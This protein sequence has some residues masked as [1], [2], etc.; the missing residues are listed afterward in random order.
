MTSKTV[1]TYRM[2]VSNLFPVGQRVNSHINF[3]YQINTVHSLAHFGD[4]KPCVT[5]PAGLQRVAEAFEWFKTS[6]VRSSFALNVDRWVRLDTKIHIYRINL[7]IYTNKF[8][9]KD[10][11]F[12]IVRRLSPTATPFSGLS[13]ILRSWPSVRT[14]SKHK[15]VEMA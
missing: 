12:S 8:M 9:F 14:L 3:L 6:R 7:M 10:T 2:T 13:L 15:N 4:V 1:L 11:H 5:P